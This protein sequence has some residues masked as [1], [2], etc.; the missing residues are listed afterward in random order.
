MTKP[1]LSYK[2]AENERS[3]VPRTGQDSQQR[4]DRNLPNAVKLNTYCQLLV[5]I[6]TITGRQYH[7]THKWACNVA[8]KEVHTCQGKP[9]DQHL[10][11]RAK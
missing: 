10:W 11:Q 3:Q 1:V 6:K 9:L 7:Y 4:L 5:Q 8:G 2:P